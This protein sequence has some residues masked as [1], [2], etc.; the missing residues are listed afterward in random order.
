MSNHHDC[1]YERIGKH[2]VCSVCSRLELDRLKKDN[3]NLK[4]MLYEELNV[5]ERLLEA[6]TG[7]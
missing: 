4:R 2:D 7:R 6:L 3:A 1:L 5:K